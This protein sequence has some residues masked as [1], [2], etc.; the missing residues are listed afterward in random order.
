MLGRTIQ[1]ASPFGRELLVVSMLQGFVLSSSRK[2]MLLFC[3][4]FHV[5]PSRNC[6]HLLIAKDREMRLR[7][8]MA[9]AEGFLGV[10]GISSAITD[11]HRADAFVL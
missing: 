7:S 5:L 1:M 11:Q 2:D 9:S 4:I 3:V 6:I 8:I 10:E